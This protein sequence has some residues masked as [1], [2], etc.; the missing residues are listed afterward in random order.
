MEGTWERPGEVDWEDTGPPELL[1]A[2]NY[3]RSTPQMPHVSYAWSWA[4]AVQEGTLASTVNHRSGSQRMLAP[5]QR[6]VPP[7]LQLG[8]EATPLILTLSWARLSTLKLPLSFGDDP[9]VE[10]L[11]VLGSALP[12]NT[13]VPPPRQWTRAGF[14]D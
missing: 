9:P 1:T 10:C 7:H 11:A 12:H 14:R 5:L 13:H 6:P 4:L 2:P 3:E 8:K